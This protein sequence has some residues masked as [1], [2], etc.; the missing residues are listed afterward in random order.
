MPFGTNPTVWRPVL[1]EKGHLQFT[2]D[3]RLRSRRV[4]G[5]PEAPAPAW[6]DQ[7]LIEEWRRK[8]G[9]NV[10]RRDVRTRC[11]RE[12]EDWQHS[13]RLRTASGANVHSSGAPIHDIWG[14]P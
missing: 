5:L 3:G 6:W 2:N 4:T 9:C 12:L 10:V 14:E 8:M 1:D 7:Y 13:E 11:Q